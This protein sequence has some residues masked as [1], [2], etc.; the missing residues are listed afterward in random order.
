LVER[1]QIEIALKLCE[2]QPLHCESK[3]PY[4]DGTFLRLKCARKLY[5]DAL[6]LARSDMEVRRERDIAI[7]QLKSLGIELGE[8][9][10]PYFVGKWKSVEECLPKIAGDHLVN[11]RYPHQGFHNDYVDVTHFRGRRHWAK[12]EEYITHWMEMPNPPCNMVGGSID[13]V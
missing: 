6:E 1:E 13:P 9:V 5:Q 4:Y 2:K 10:S 3:C 8:D 11:Y 7:G 12:N